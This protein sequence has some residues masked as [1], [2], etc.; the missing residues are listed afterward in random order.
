MCLVAM[1]FQVVI[2]SALIEGK[3]LLIGS[4]KKTEVNFQYN[5]ATDIHLHATS[6][7]LEMQMEILFAQQSF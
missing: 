2:T 7:V 4:H 6:N 3:L 1:I 5:R